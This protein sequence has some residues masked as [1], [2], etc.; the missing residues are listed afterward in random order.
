M[1][2][3]FKMAT[4]GNNWIFNT[5]TFWHVIY[6]NL[7]Q[8]LE[9]SWWIFGRI[10]M[11]NCLAWNPS[12]L[13]CIL[14]VNSL[15]NYLNVFHSLIDIGWLIMWNVFKKMIIKHPRVR[16]FVHSYIIWMILSTS[17]TSYHVRCIDVFCLKLERKKEM[18][19]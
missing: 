7:R 10:I 6:V 17:F 5:W 12:V 9:I 15:A 16:F 3:K 2:R 1:N 18:N 11:I 19:K 4:S 14:V 8:L 13:M